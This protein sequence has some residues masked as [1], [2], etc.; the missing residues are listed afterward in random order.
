MK[1]LGCG[2]LQTYTPA[3]A[4]E[5]PYGLILFTGYDKVFGILQAAGSCRIDPYLYIQ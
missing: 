1:L 5:V 4:P 2:R 3:S